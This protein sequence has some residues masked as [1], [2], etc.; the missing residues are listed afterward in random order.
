MFI[1]IISIVGSLTFLSRILGYSR[2]L[3]I[4]RIL[5]AGIVSDA[6]FVSF[7]LPNLFRRLFAEGAMNSAFVPVLSGIKVKEGMEKANYFLSEIL[8]IIF[9]FLFPFIVIFEIFMP[10]IIDLVAP[11]F[12]NMS[13]KFELTVHLSRLTFPFL[14]FIC[15]T[16]LIGGYLNTMSKFA[17]MAFTPVILNIL[18][19]LSLFFSVYNSSDQELTSRYLAISISLAG[20]IQFVW[21]IYNLKKNNFDIK[22]NFFGKLLKFEIS[23]NA[24]RLFYLFLPAVIGNGVYQINLLIDMILASTLKDG[25][26][27][28]LY[29]ADRVNQ[30]PLGVFGIAL[31]TALL[32]I[33]A[34]QIKKNFYEKSI[35]T[36]NHCLQIGILLIIPASFGIFLLAEKIIITLFVGG[37]FTL[38]D[39]VL[40]SKALKALCIGLPAFIFVKILSVI[41]FAREDTRTPVYVAVA[42]MIINLTFNLILID[43]YFH[44]GLAIATTIS[45]WFNFTCLL[46][47]LCRKKIIKISKN[48]L[49]IFF[50][51][52]LSSLIMILSIRLLL[53]INYFTILSENIFVINLLKLLMV[54]I[55]G[56]LV[57]GF[58]IYLFKLS[59]LLN[60]KLG[61]GDSKK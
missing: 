3:L 26:I 40:T 25:S 41:F 11:G 10:L 27:S 28:Y 4:A 5:G 38:S 22:L 60:F 33:L 53:E 1:R 8:T 49:Q 47:I 24:K 7:K 17:A 23:K 44:V 12:E 54:I 61:E 45:S 55:F 48:T 51:S 13:S 20:I 6:F 32:P 18:M 16:S 30:L 31:S 59:S 37:E 58:L 36:I 15:M 52:I 46:I 14:L 29:F 34:E 57:Y 2:D 19:I 43:F 9:S 21:L 42:S 35:A 39:S 56:S 50:K